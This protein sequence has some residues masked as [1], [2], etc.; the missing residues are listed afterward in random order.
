MNNIQWNINRNSFIVIQENA[1]A[2]VF[3]KMAAI[4][5]RLQYVNR[6]TENECHD[7]LIQIFSMT[8]WWRM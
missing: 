8:M 7:I 3:S 2:N 4:L 5:S 6:I 1:L